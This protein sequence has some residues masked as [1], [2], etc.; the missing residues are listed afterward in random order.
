MHSNSE[1]NPRKTTLFGKA[2]AKQK[3][4]AKQTE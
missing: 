2:I 1:M 4:K 3:S